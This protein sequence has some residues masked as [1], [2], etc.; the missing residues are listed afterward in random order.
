MRRQRLNLISNRDNVLLLYDD[1]RNNK[2]LRHLLRRALANNFQNGLNLEV[3]ALIR[4]RHSNLLGALNELDEVSLHVLPALETCVV[5]EHHALENV[6]LVDI[7]KR[8]L[9]LNQ[10]NQVAYE[11]HCLVHLRILNRGHRLLGLFGLGGHWGDEVL[12][13]QFKGHQV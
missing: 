10:L 13:E 12:Q 8:V 7:Q 2:R 9:H 5:V 1:L 6:V 11:L 3:S 4:D